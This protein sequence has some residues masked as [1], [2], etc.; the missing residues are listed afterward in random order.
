MASSSDG[1]LRSNNIPQLITAM[2]SLGFPGGSDSKDSTCNVG[3][4]GSI[5]WLGRSPGG[6]HGNQLQYS[7][8]KNPMVRGA[9]CHTPQGRK[10]LD[11]TEVT[12]HTH[13]SLGKVRGYF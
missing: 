3:D 6:G 7:C 2:L 8:P 9:W 4:T 5:P 13:K 10:E 12:G 11:M 1:Q